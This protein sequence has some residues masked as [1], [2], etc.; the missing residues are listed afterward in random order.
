MY[1]SVCI[2]FLPVGQKAFVMRE[3]TYTFGIP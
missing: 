3:I 1:D 2:I